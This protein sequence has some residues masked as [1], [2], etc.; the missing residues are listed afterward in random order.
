MNS[1][2]TAALHIKLDQLQHQQQVG[3]QVVEKQL[4]ETEGKLNVRLEAIGGDMKEEMH[5]TVTQIAAIAQRDQGVDTPNIKQSASSPHSP[6]CA[7]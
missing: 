2:D 3:Q 4:Q 1:F 6:V 7:C 5:Q